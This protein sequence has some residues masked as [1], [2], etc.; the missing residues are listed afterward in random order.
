M[1]KYILFDLDGTITDPGEGITNSVAYALDRYGIQVSDKYPWCE[2]LFLS[3]DVSVG[4]IDNYQK[5]KR[6]I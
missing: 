5:C 3:K 4:G 1:L 6:K 2:T